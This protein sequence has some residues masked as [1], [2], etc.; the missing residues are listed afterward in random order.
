MKFSATAYLD[1]INFGGVI[2]L[3]SAE[4]NNKGVRMILS[5]SL[6]PP[7]FNVDISAR[8]TILGLT[9]AVKVNIN[10]SRL[11]FYFTGPILGGV[12]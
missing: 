12:F 8:A 3:T 6:L 7:S 9:T 4:S 2:S 5:A 1:P 10:P 11:Y